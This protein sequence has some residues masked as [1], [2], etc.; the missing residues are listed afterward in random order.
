MK[1]KKVA[2][3][4]SAYLDVDTTLVIAEADEPAARASR[5]FRFS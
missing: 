4:E 5:R 3:P 1:Q 2:H